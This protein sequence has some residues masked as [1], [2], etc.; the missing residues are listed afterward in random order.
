MAVPKQRHTKSRRNKRRMHLFIEPA[1]LISC[2]KCGKPVLPHTA[3]KNCGY[4]KSREIIDVMKKLNK[5]EKKLKEKEMA[6]QEK[7]QEEK[8]PL[9][10]ERLSQK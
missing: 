4:Y 3:C 8:K 7:E 5:K 10:A 2:P 6:N 9:T 1:A